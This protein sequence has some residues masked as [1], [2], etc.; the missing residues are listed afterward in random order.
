MRN[1]TIAVCF[2]GL[3]LGTTR[4]A[5]AQ[6]ETYKVDPVHTMVLFRIKHLGVSY[7]HGRLNDI[8]GRFTID[9]ANPAASKVELEIKAA[10]IDT[11]DAKRDQHLKGPDFFNVKQFPR[12][13]F[14]ST[15]MT[16][17]DDAKDLWEVKGDLSLHGVT[18]EITVKVERVGA[19]K[20]PWGGYRSGAEMVFTI[21]RSDYKM[22]YMEGAIGD[23]VR[24]TVAVEG[25]RQ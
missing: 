20:D 21:K 14:K 24:L 2:L 23:E 6:A 8:S 22:N 13:T 16:R 4:Q 18:K 17:T 5:Q 7:T 3:L 11:N 10:S 15:S 12:I 19:G 1:T 25:I 9:T